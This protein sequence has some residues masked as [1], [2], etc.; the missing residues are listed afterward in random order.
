MGDPAKGQLDDYTIRWFKV[1]GKLLIN[2]M[3]LTGM[4]PLI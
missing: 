1:D 4:Y 2:I 3:V